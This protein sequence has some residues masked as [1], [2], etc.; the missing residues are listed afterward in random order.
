MEKYNF[1]GKNLTNESINTASKSLDE[2]HAIEVNKEEPNY[3]EPTQEEIFNINKTKELIET[4][5]KLLG[6]NSSNL[7]IN[8]YQF[9]FLKES[10]G[11]GNYNSETQLIEIED[12]Y[13]IKLENIFKNPVTIIPT[14]GY[15]VQKILLKIIK[16]NK[17]S[18]TESNYSTILHESIHGKSFHKYEL[19]IDESNPEKISE[20]IYR[21]GYLLTKNG[22]EDYF[23]GLNEGIVDKTTMDILIKEYK[24]EPDII[25]KIRKILYYIESKYFIEMLTIDAIVNKIAQNKNEEKENVWASFKKGQFTGEMMHLR[26]IEKVYGS[27]SLRVLATMNPRVNMVNTKNFLYYTYFSTKSDLIRKIIENKLFSKEIRDETK[28]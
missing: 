20:N 10:T 2:A 14:V 7:D 13:K 21:T 28:K 22:Q 24:N 16:L 15:F 9:K 19:N 8:K 12:K 11:R 27:G 25:N 5:M 1:V 23:R 4:E 6:V 3:R 18:K 26:D 17:N